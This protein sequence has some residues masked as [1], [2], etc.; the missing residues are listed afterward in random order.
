MNINKVGMKFRVVNQFR[1][2]AWFLLNVI[3][4]SFNEEIVLSKRN[5][6][7]RFGSN[8]RENEYRMQN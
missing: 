2:I 5:T 3:R 4:R 1:I 7:R 8:I 6:K